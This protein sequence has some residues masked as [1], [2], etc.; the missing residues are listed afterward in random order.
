VATDDAI[1]ADLS[2]R[3]RV[4]ARAR[5]WREAAQAHIELWGSLA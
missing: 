1:R 5:T 4:Y 2:A 3:G